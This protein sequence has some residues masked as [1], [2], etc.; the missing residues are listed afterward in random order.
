[1][2]KF[3]FRLFFCL[4]LLA[5]NKEAGAQGFSTM[6]LQPPSSTPIP[7]LSDTAGRLYVIPDSS[8]SA[9]IATLYTSAALEGSKVASATPKVLAGA[10]VT[11]S[12]TAGYFMVWNST[13]VPA[14]GAV[15]PALC[16]YIPASPY[17]M[18]FNLNFNGTTGVS[19]AFSTTGCYIK[20]VSAT[21]TF[22]LWTTPAP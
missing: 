9:G 17:S 4:A 6:F 10:A 3:I 16:F 13:T 18:A 12:S 1:M 11:T 5:L 7:A 8:G 14:D 22:M 2:L 19:V 20:T 15:T 21:V